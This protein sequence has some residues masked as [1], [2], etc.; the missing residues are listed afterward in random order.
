MKYI[1][2]P[3]NPGTEMMV[4]FNVNALYTIWGVHSTT[5]DPEL[6]NEFTNFFP[7]LGGG[8]FHNL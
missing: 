1:S 2:Y 8:A 3:V 5:F 7:I 6:R 4:W